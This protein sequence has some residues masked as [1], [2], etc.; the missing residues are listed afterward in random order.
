MNKKKVVKK[1]IFVM[2]VVTLFLIATLTPQILGKSH[3]IQN[4]KDNNETSVK[5]NIRSISLFQR[6]L[7][8]FAKK[9]P[10]SFGILTGIL[11]TN[12]NGV[13]KSTDVFFYQFKE[14]DVD[15]NPETGVN[16]NDIRVQY[17][18]AP[19]FEF[20]TD[21][22]LGIAFIIKIDRIGDEIKENDFSATFE[23][24]DNEINLGFNSKSEPGNEIPDSTEITFSIYF[25]FFAQTRGFEISIN[26]QYEGGNEGKKIDLFAAYNSEDEEREISIQFNPAIQIKTGFLTTKKQG[27]W[28]YKFYRESSLSSEV[29]TS[30]TTVDNNVVK[31]ISLTIDEIPKDMSFELGLTPLSQGGGQL[32]Y[33]SSE[34][35]NVELQISSGQI[36]DGGFLYL[37][38]TPRRIFSEWSPTISNGE[39]HIQIDSDGTDFIVKD[40]ETNPFVNF[41]INGLEN[42]DFDM[43]WN[44]TNPGDLKIYRKSGLSIDFDFE[45]GDWVARLDGQPDADIIYA[46]W[47]IDNTGYVI[48]DTNWKPL[49]TVELFVKGPNVGLWTVGEAFKAED[50]RIDWTLWPPQEWNLVVTGDL[51][52]LSISIDIFLN[53]QWYH[54][55]PWVD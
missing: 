8:R 49:S 53:G 42:V 45:L 19:W 30:F 4:E 52:F 55:W 14:I 31:D 39:Y 10:I 46:D 33:E 34:M 6:L 36:R 28:R 3:T 1:N 38:N 16:G 51:S 47:Y 50:F 43:Y 11:N 29:K 26:P 48:F 15:D 23:I 13:E 20:D 17:L 40:A 12:C 2:L 32:L 22:G 27:V 41:E 21:I 35:Y 24:L 9:S 7:G 5:N 18:L 37:K 44:L 25:Y 54:L